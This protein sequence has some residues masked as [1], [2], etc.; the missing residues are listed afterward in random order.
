MGLVPWREFKTDDPLQ[1]S[2]YSK[3]GPQI[4]ADLQTVY[5]RS[6]INQV[7]QGT[8]ITIWISNSQLAYLFSWTGYKQ[9]W[10]LRNSCGGVHMAW[11]ELYISHAQEI[12]KQKHDTGN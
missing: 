2:A 6:T 1:G 3:F 12:K 4:N 5:Y 10:M 8:L 9:V 7:Q 11:H